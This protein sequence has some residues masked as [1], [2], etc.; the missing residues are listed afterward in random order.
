MHHDRAIFNAQADFS[1]ILEK[2]KKKSSYDTK[3]NIFV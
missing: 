3:K 2:E 1:N